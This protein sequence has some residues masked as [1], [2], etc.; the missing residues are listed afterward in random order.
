MGR[1]TAGL[2]GVAGSSHQGPID[3]STELELRKRQRRQSSLRT[4]PRR[5]QRTS[6]PAADRVTWWQVTHSG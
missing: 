3:R 5:G 4:S 1:S 6:G 2:S